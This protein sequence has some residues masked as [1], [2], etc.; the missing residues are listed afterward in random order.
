MMAL[1]PLSVGD[2]GFFANL[3]PLCPSVLSPHSVPCKLGVA[4][5][6][7]EKKGSERQRDVLRVTT[8]INR[9]QMRPGAQVSWGQDEGPPIARLP[10]LQRPDLTVGQDGS[11]VGK[12]SDRGCSV[13]GGPGR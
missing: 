6:W 5:S 8:F 1:Q 4:M 13:R 10:L 11:G 7:V 9:G 3:E 2:T 12:V